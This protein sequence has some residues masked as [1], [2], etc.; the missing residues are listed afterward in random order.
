M[1]QYQDSNQ[2]KIFHVDYL[3]FEGKEG[4]F[5]NHATEHNCWLSYL[6]FIVPDEAGQALK[7]QRKV[8]KESRWLAVF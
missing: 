2:L 3:N 8:T 1:R 7:K 5:N 6:L 4:R